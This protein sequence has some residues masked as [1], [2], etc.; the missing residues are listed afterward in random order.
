VIDQVR[1]Q[2]Q[3]VLL[4]Q[5]VFVH[6]PVRD[7]SYQFLAPAQVSSDLLKGPAFAAEPDPDLDAVGRYAA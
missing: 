3:T 6:T 7:V 5:G 2:E 4:K 1:S